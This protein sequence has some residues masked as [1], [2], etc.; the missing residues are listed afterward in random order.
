MGRTLLV[1]G[2]LLLTVA[3]FIGLTVPLADCPECA[4]QDRCLRCGGRGSLT[5]LERWGRRPS[6]PYLVDLY[7][8][9]GPQLLSLDLDLEA[10]PH[11]DAYSWNGRHGYFEGPEVV[12][13]DG[14]RLLAVFDW[15]VTSAEDGSPCRVL[16]FERTGEEIDR[17]EVWLENSP[18]LLA[19]LKSAEAA[20]VLRVADVGPRSP[21]YFIRRAGEEATAVPSG[22]WPADWPTTGIGRIVA[23]EGRLVLDPP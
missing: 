1:A 11:P 16:L 8:P 6:H 13:V 5:L 18:H 12:R 19:E 3:G 10:A 14:S 20:V 15:T 2:L 9:E 21:N 22:S 7:R 4:E 17:L 23:R